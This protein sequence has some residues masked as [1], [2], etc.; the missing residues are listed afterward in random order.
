MLEQ[1]EF[2]GVLTSVGDLV[3]KRP[4]YF[5]KGAAEAMA[6]KCVHV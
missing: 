2:R 4:V 6:A 3:Q 5:G 1:Q